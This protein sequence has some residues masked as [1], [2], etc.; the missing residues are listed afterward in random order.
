LQLLLLLHFILVSP[1]VVAAR[2]IG[3]CKAAALAQ[4]V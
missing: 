3:S 2:P 4:R 1:C